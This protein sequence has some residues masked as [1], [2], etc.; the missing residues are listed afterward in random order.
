MTSILSSVGP[1]R[2]GCGK[3]HYWLGFLKIFKTE[4]WGTNGMDFKNQDVLK[5]DA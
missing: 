5:I 3:P 1:E 2:K 4:I